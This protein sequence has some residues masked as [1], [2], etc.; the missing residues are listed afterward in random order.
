MVMKNVEVWRLMK[1]YKIFKVENGRSKNEKLP[2]FRVPIVRH[3][4]AMFG[5]LSII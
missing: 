3:M 4:I 2:L 5:R 1:R